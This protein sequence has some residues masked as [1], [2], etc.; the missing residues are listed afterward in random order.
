[1]Q[2]GPARPAGQP[3]RGEPIERVGRTPVAATLTSDAGWERGRRPVVNVSWGD[4]RRCAQ[5]LSARIGQTWRLPT[6]IGW[7]RAAASFSGRP[8]GRN[9]GLGFRACRA[10]APG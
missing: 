10:S 1:V 8:D 4:A 3:R 7:E 5:W 6:E 2:L 9:V